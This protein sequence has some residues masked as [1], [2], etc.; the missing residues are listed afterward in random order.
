MDSI[1]QNGW[2]LL[3]ERAS[4]AREGREG[5]GGPSSFL[6]FL[7]CLS[8]KTEMKLQPS[9]SVWRSNLL[10]E[11]NPQPTKKRWTPSFLPPH[12]FSLSTTNLPLQTFHSSAPKLIHNKAHKSSC[13]LSLNTSLYIWSYNKQ[14]Q[15]CS[16]CCS[17]SIDLELNLK[18]QTD[19]QRWWHY[20]FLSL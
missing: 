4:A 10:C 15:S 18:L 8:A 7:V 9:E 3:H 11:N 13:L 14:S 2:V 16:F 6:R 1:L 17:I 19:R 5:R 12:L 20:S